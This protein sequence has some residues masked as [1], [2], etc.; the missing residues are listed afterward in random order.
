M[1][2]SNAHIKLTEQVRVTPAKTNLPNGSHVLWKG[3]LRRTTWRHLDPNR[4][5]GV[6]RVSYSLQTAV[7]REDKTVS[8]GVFHQEEAPASELQILTDDDLKTFI[9]NHSSK[10]NETTMTTT[11]HS[12]KSS[13]STANG[14]SKKS[15]L[16]AGHTGKPKA[17]AAAKKPSNAEAAAA[18]P[19]ASAGAAAPTPKARKEKLPPARRLERKIANAVKRWGNIAKL[20]K[21]WDAKLD[22][23]LADVG[24]LMGDVV[25]SSAALPDDFAPPAKKGGGGGGGTGPRS[26]VVGSIVSLT[27]R[28]KPK[29]DGILEPTEMTNLKVLVMINGKVRCRTEE[30]TTIALPRAHVMLAAPPSAASGVAAVTDADAEDDAPDSES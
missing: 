1:S 23:A 20:A 14:S 9:T 3:S 30:N 17:N 11:V 15:T 12:T 6:G 22:T 28:A 16:P 4:K 26:V 18:K 27:D 29:Y 25:K 24:E 13:T 10:G 8:W 21:G 2:L 19:K 7:I 5:P